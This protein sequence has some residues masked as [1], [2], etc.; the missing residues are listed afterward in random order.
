MNNKITFICAE[1]KAIAEESNNGIDSG[2]TLK[3]NKCGKETII[4]LCTI[5]KYKQICKDKNE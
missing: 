2:T 1:C 3:C 4:L 5:K